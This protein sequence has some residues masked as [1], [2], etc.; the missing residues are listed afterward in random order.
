MSDDVRKALDRLQHPNP[1]IPKYA[2]HCWSVPAYRKRIQMAPDPDK[3]N[4]FDKNPTKR[5][6]SIV[7]TMIYYAW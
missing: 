5:I 1:K 4:L 6:Q 7:M 2:P 3:I